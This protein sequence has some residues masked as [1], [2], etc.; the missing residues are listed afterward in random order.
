MIKLSELEP[1]K[2]YKITFDDCCVQGELVGT[3]LRWDKDAEGESPDE[4]I[5]YRAFFNFGEIEGWAWE[6]EEAKE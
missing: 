2:R 3:F 4:L 1:G 5:Y 6:V